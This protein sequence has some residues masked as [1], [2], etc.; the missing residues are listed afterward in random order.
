MLT[1]DGQRALAA[2]TAARLE[3]GTVRVS[4]GS[5]SAE[6]P[7]LAVTAQDGRVEVEA[8]FGGQDAN[9][10]W[11]VRELVAS[12]GTV[13]DRTE[14]DMGRKSE[15]SLWAVDATVGFQSK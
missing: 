15:G 13:L 6:S 2:D 10:E 11:R 8:E 3:G 7:I 4:D 14:A 9:F 1:P 12:D 5:S